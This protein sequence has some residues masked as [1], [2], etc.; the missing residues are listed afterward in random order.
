MTAHLIPDSALK[1]LPVLPVQLIESAVVF[2][3]AGL[4]FLFYKKARKF[5]G[6]VMSLSFLCYATVRFLIEYL[7][8]NP[9]IGPFTAAQWTSLFVFSLGL[10]LLIRFSGRKPTS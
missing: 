1:S 5:D 2:V 3:L 6:Q 10:V 4:L 8:V 7:R 9:L